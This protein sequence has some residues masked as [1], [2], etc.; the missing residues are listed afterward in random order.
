MGLARHRASYAEELA[1]RFVRAPCGFSRRLAARLAKISN[2][3]NE[4]A[5]TGKSGR[6]ALIG[7][8]DRG[9]VSADRGCNWNSPSGPYRSL[10]SAS[11]QKVQPK[12]TRAAVNCD[13]A[14]RRLQALYRGCMGNPRVF[15]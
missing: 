10:V 14:R 3:N 8:G 9:G 12:G 15:K 5:R 6:V 4:P 11:D 2:K 7:A 13:A 1:G